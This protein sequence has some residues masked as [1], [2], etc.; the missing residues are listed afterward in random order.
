M[1]IIL[2]IIWIS[3][4]ASKYLKWNHRKKNCTLQVNAT[5]TDILERKPMRG[6]GM[7]YKPIFKVTLNNESIIINSAK[8]SNL[9]Q[10]HNGELVE[11]LLNPNNTS[12]FLYVNNKYNV[13]KTADIIGCVI[14]L[15][16]IIIMKFNF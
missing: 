9:I 14:L 15:L 8:Y 5:V 10:L 6:S 2:I 16:L 3:I 1:Y 13:G 12:E 4:T 7:L 11:L